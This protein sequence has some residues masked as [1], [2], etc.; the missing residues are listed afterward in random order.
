MSTFNTIDPLSLGVW[1]FDSEATDHTTPFLKLFN[2]YVKITK[3]LI[4]VANGDTVPIYV[5]PG[6]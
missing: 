1:M 3:Q 6:I 5:D 4:T 2:S